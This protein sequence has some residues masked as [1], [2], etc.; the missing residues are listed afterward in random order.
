MHKVIDNYIHKGIASE[1]H[2]SIVARFNLIRYK[3]FCCYDSLIDRAKAFDYIK[4]ADFLFAQ[5][6]DL[7]STPHHFY[8]NSFQAGSR[9]LGLHTT[10]QSIDKVWSKHFA[11]L[12]GD[13]DYEGGDY[14]FLND[15]DAVVCG[16]PTKEDFSRVEFKNNRMIESDPKKKRLL[17]YVEESSAPALH[18]NLLL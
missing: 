1:I 15:E 2:G 18:L 16:H 8:I 14:H 9:S 6:A 12:L 3:S 4:E 17:S 10:D 13:G 5:Y 11:L 7:N